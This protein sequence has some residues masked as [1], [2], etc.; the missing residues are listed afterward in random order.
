MGKAIDELISHTNTVASRRASISQEIVH[1]RFQL[2]LM[3]QEAE[4]ARTLNDSH[5]VESAQDKAAKLAEEI[6]QLE[7]NRFGLDEKG[8][9]LAQAALEELQQQNGID[10]EEYSELLHQVEVLQR[11]YAEGLNKLGDAHRRTGA[12]KVIFEKNVQP[13]LRAGTPAPHFPALI[14]PQAQ[15]LAFPPDLV[16]KALRGETTKTPLVTMQ[17]KFQSIREESQRASISEGIRHRAYLEEQASIR[18]SLE[19]S[20][21]DTNVAP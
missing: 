6:Q 20:K 5:R 9:Q 1:L 13:Y 17:E 19:T 16:S 11:V 18:A 4:T 10:L 14:L 8:I 3:E 15:H 12:A 2:S 21:E 7:S